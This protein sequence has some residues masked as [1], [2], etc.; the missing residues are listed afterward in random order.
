MLSDEHTA[1]REHPVDLGCQECLVPVGDQP[2]RAI[3]ERQPP[4]LSSALV[5]VVRRALVLH[6]RYAQR[7]QP[8]GGDRDARWSGFG[9]NG[10]WRPRRELRQALPA[11]RAHVEHGAH[12]CS[13]AGELPLVAPRRPPQLRPGCQPGKVPPRKRSAQSLA[14]KFIKR[15][16]PTSFAQPPRAVSCPSRARETGQA[17]RQ[18]CRA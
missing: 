6:D 5:D 4:V 9:R 14:D 13:A 8:S 1:R 17:R 18:R 10:H 12:G 15:R 3:A 2:E 11:A 7:T 16:H